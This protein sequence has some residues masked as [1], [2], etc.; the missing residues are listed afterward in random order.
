[1]ERQKK[2]MQEEH[3]GLQEKKRDAETQAA[4]NRIEEC[5]MQ[6]LVEERSKKLSEH[7]DQHADAAA[8]IS[9]LQQVCDG[10]S[11]SAGGPIAAF[12]VT[13][14][15]GSQSIEADG[16]ICH[17][18]LEQLRIENACLI[19]AAQRTIGLQRISDELKTAIADVK[20]EIEGMDAKLS[21]PWP[22]SETSGTA[23]ELKQ[24]YRCLKEEIQL[25]EVSQ[26]A[27]VNEDGAAD[28][29]ETRR[30]EAERQL[31][32][33]KRATKQNIQDFREGI[34][35]LMGWKVDQR[36]SGKDVRWHL[37][38][39]YQPDKE[40]AF[41]R[42]ASSGGEVS[43]DLLNTRWAEELQRSPADMA[44]LEK[45]SSVPGFLAHLTHEC[46]AKST[47]PH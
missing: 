31:E 3:R 16:K 40:L 30:Q 23:D 37:T 1:L 39:K 5:K 41:G 20:N 10:S 8:R 35:L 19:E 44:F 24:E 17:E 45:R 9:V 15:L 34:Y 32:R 36:G 7:L 27:L 18:E 26:S 38:S 21:R 2:T 43:V 11:S 13:G 14:D 22:P 4:Q 28:D 46:L 42:G 47:L 33:Y 6:K 29:L 25:L 12:E